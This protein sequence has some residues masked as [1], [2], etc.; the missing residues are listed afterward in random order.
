MMMRLFPIGPTNL[1]ISLAHRFLHTGLAYG[2][3]NMGDYKVIA[4]DLSL[5]FKKI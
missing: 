5:M 4:L 1:I 2:I 3:G